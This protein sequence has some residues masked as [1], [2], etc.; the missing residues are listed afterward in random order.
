VIYDGTYMSFNKE[1]LSFPDLI[2]E[3]Q[4]G[5]IALEGGQY[6]PMEP[7]PP[8]DVIPGSINVL[9]QAESGTIRVVAPGLSGFYNNFNNGR[10]FSGSER[11]RN[12]E[13]Q[14]VLKLPNETSQTQSTPGGNNTPQQNANIEFRILYEDYATLDLSLE[15]YSFTITTDPSLEYQPL[16]GSSSPPVIVQRFSGYTYSTSGTSYSDPRDNVLYSYERASSIAPDFVQEVRQEFVGV[17]S[18]SPR[19]DFDQF[20]ERSWASGTN[21]PIHHFPTNYSSIFGDIIINA[22]T[23]VAGSDFF[24]DQILSLVDFAPQLSLKQKEC[25][26]PDP[27]LLDLEGVKKSVIKEFEE[28]QCTTPRATLGSPNEASPL[29]EASIGG[30]ISTIIRLYLVEFSLRSLFV[31]SRFPLESALDKTEIID[32]L[33]QDY[34]TT[35]IIDSIGNLDEKYSADFQRQSVLYHNKISKENGWSKTGSSQ[36]AISNIVSQQLRPVIARMLQILGVDFSNKSVSEMFVEDWLPLFDIPTE[37]YE[38]RFSDITDITSLS[39]ISQ[40]GSARQGFDLEDGN[41][42]L[43]RYISKE[44]TDPNLFPHSTPWD[45]GVVSLKRF[46]ELISHTSI[47]QT[48]TVADYFDINK[49]S[50]GLR[51][52]FLPPLGEKAS[53]ALAQTDSS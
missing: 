31:L 15:K 20:V 13:T 29:D 8:A 17:T 26:C 44:F 42:I 41:L 35:L 48:R 16:S 6:P 10:I 7:P 38:N 40:S 30:V 51:L 47:D 49:L 53:F 50:I 2:T 11:V 9:Q 34:F 43:E 23:H 27:H 4:E 25:G 5:S 3:E 18:Y 46:K 39:N 45:G 52:T 28:A 36:V 37:Q 21:S 32:S 14:F 33:I 12:G 22:A 24:N 1:V 19:S